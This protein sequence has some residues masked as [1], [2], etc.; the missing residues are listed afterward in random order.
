MYIMIKMSDLLR[1][2]YFL[3]KNIIGLEFKLILREAIIIKPCISNA[4]D[5]NDGSF[6][7][8]VVLKI[9]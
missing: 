5:V 1:F 7:L 3:D 4:G 8:I 2:V 9:I 6:L